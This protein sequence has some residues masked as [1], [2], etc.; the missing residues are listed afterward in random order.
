MVSDKQTTGQGEN[1]M[2]MAE[3]KISVREQQLESNHYTERSNFNFI[4]FG[5]ILPKESN[6]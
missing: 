6:K 4:N 5:F 3:V 2:S 1:M